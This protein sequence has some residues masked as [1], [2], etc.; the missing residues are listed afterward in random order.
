V[1]RTS[2]LVVDAENVRRSIWPNVTLDEL[3]ELC[4]RHAHAAAVEVVVVLD[5]PAAVEGSDRLRLVAA[6]GR[7]ADDLIVELAG[8]LAPGVATVATSDRGLRVRLADSGV[9][10]LGGGALVRDLL[11]HR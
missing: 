7:S 3:V 1:P 4:D 11:R 9:S 2:L 10:F 6:D 5:R 8:T